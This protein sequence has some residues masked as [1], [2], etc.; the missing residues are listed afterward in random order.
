M[1]SIFFPVFEF[2]FFILLCFCFNLVWKSWSCTLVLFVPCTRSVDPQSCSGA[3]SNHN[4]D[5]VSLL[6]S[7]MLN[8]HVV[9]FCLRF[10]L[11]IRGSIFPLC[12]C[13][14][15][16]LAFLNIGSCFSFVILCFYSA[17]ILLQYL[18]WVKGKKWGTP[19][20]LT[21]YPKLYVI[22]SLFSCYT[23]LTP[24]HLP[25]PRLCFSTLDSWT[26]SDPGTHTSVPTMTYL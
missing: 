3:P 17:G 8:V 6:R 23:S 10:H 21:H 4:H 19:Y 16:Y 24:L 13:S 18:H 15:L 22:P 2:L 9:L 11:F 7:W 25:H 1:D 20:C 12:S 5:V 26:A 14:F